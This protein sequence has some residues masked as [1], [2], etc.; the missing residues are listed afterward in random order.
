M[1]SDTIA[2]IATAMSSS[3]IGI[4]RISGSRA[5]EIA[6]QVFQSRKKNV[7]LKE[8]QTHTVHYGMVKDGD[9]IIDEVLAVVMRGPHSYTAEDTVEIDCHG[10]VLIMKKILETVIKYGARPAEPGE[11]TKR[12]FLN[13]RIDLSQ[14][15]AVMDLIQSKNE[16]AMKNSISQLKGSLSKKIRKMRAELLY[17][18]AFIES[19]LDDPEH[20]S[21][22]GYEERLEEKLRPLM[23]EMDGMIRS[24]DNGR[25]ASEGIRTVILGKPNAGKSSLMNVL[26][27]EERAIVTDI[28]GTTRDTLEESMQ[29]QGISLNIV[30][31][32]GIRRTEDL[33]EQIG[34]SRARQM[35]DQADLIIYVV[36]GSQPLD[37]NDETIMEMIRDRKVLVILNKTDLAT[38]ISESELSEKTGFPVIAASARE[39]TGID[40]LERQI[41]NMFYEGKIDFNDEVVITNVRHKTALT[42]AA[43]SL[44]MVMRSI[45]N[46]MPEDFLTIDLMDAYERLGT[47]IGE[48]AGEDLVNEI[49]SRFCMGK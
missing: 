44:R 40:E 23:K 19:A 25:I 17:E 1:H 49:F 20:I 48:S 45:E 35:A 37:E 7:S 39:E 6:D 14:A 4:V 22:D 8:A 13:G 18:I 12:A 9:Q 32:A 27:G 36:D 10:G 38:V 29:L 11:F 30:D 47:V 28:A 2:A 5:F 41:Q 15:E 21:L 16:Y 3:G 31:T 33:V 26:L 34:V 43:E 24:A 42:E 46:R